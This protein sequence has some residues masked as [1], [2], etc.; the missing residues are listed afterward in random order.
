LCTGNAPQS[1]QKIPLNTS[2]ELF[3]LANKAKKQSGVA[4]RISNKIDFQP[5]GYFILIKRKI[6]QH[7]FSIL[8]IYVT[9]A[10]PSTFIKETLQKLEE[11]I[12][13]YTI[14]VGDFNN[15][16]SAMDRS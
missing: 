13:P 6:C 9:M 12:V 10:K 4:I 16:L 1:R 8:N 11:H 3:F 7:K 15:P 14:I 2:I 5:N